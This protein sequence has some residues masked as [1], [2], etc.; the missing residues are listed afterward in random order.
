MV[1]L[2]FFMLS[3]VTNLTNPVIII[4]VLLALVAASLM[5]FSKRLSKKIFKPKNDEELLNIVLRLKLIAMTI[6][7]VGVILVV[8]SVQ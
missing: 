8:F 7:F 5:I 3:I 6:A 4:G 1:Q 2:L